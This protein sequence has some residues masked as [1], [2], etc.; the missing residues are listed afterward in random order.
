VPTRNVRDYRDKVKLSTSCSDTTVVTPTP[1]RVGALKLWLTLRDSPRTPR[2][3]TTGDERKLPGSGRV[4][5][6]SL[7]D[8]L[9]SQ[10]AQSS[11]SKAR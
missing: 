5:K 6:R 3:T 1:Q 11:P 8:S 7:A 2:L 10:K 9:E 4:T